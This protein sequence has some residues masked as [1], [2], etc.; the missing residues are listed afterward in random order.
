M[1]SL[2]A[3]LLYTTTDQ[4]R[5]RR[6]IGHDRLLHCGECKCAVPPH[7]P[8]PCR[9]V[10]PDEATSKR[11][12]TVR[13]KTTP[14]S[15]RKRRPTARP[16]RKRR[17]LG[18]SGNRLGFRSQRM[19]SRSARRSLRNGASACVHRCER[20]RAVRPASIDGTARAS[21]PRCAT[22]PAADHR[23]DAG[24]SRERAA[25]TLHRPKCSACSRR[26]H[27]CAAVTSACSASRR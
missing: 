5:V 20:R 16:E 1:R 17:G 4:R 3:D 15:P 27:V 14:G 2:R 21:T 24:C 22:P 23:S 6:T 26:R 13:R 9:R 8:F 18:L 25:N 19:D 11:R 10:R 7:P 12:S